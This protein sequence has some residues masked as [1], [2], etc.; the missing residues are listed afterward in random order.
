MSLISEPAQAAP[1]PGRHRTL[2]RLVAVLVVVALLG[3]ILGRLPAGPPTAGAA[4]A[5]VDR[6][7]VTILGGDPTTLDPAA[8]GDLG[9]AQVTAQ[10]FESVTAVDPSLNVQPALASGWTSSD[11]GRS[12][13]FTLRPGLKFS[14][15][16]PLGAADVVRSWLRLVNPAHPSPLASL[17][18]EIHGV[19]PYLAGQTSDPSTVGLKADGN[20]VVVTF[21]Q[22]GDGLSGPRLGAGLRGRARRDR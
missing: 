4:P 13:T 21:D 9:S 1:A 3:L 22:P 7:S 19:G 12:I 16:T 14:D 11:G 6:S 10:L 18:S 5:T 8:Q 15:G 20:T 17:L 2:A